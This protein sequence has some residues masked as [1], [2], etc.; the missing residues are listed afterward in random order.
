MNLWVSDGQAIYNVQVQGDAD[1]AFQKLRAVWK[2]GLCVQS[3]DAPTEARRM[4]VVDAVQ[5]VLP[6]GQ[7]LTISGGGIKPELEVQVVILTPEI[8][9]AVRK[10]AEEV[11]FTLT[12]VFTP[13]D[14]TTPSVAPTDPATPRLQ[15][16]TG[17]GVVQ[18][19]G[20]ELPR[21]CLSIAYSDPI[22]CEGPIL[23]GD[24]A[25]DGIPSTEKDGVRT[26]DGYVSVTGEYDP[27]DGDFGS[28]LN[29]EPPIPAGMP[30]VEF[31]QYSTLC[32]VPDAQWPD[33]MM[34][35]PSRI[36]QDLGVVKQ[37]A[38]ERLTGP[39]DEAARDALVDSLRRV[40]GDVVLGLQGDGNDVLLRVVYADDDLL[41]KVGDV[42]EDTGMPVAVRTA[43]TPVGGSDTTLVV[44]SR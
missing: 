9:A 4:E 10:A 2:G 42:V 40:A 25:W 31:T 29:H 3:S 21:L 15:T 22:H 41:E 28:L 34:G 36:G 30:G 27:A 20:G 23:T 7:L 32:G 19:L 39:V 26:S 5:A 1:A 6:A 12:A 17:S 35:D 44:P 33:I 18:Q 11:P 14:A 38:C 37:R 24:F 8:E 13:V 43:L 16:L